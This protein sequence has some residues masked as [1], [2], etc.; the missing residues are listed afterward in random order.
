MNMLY[1][2]D[3]LEDH[4]FYPLSNNHTIVSERYVEYLSDNVSYL[5][6]L[7]DRSESALCVFHANTFTQ[8]TLF[9]GKDIYI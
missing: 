2:T 9:N 3:I 1:F 5:H 4:L 6:G 7:H 8:E